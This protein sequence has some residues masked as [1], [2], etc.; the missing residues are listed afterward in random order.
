MS[1]HNHSHDISETSGIK[2]FFVVL[3]NVLITLSEFIGG[4][5]SGSLALLSDSIHN[6]SDV[7]AVALSYFAIKI[8]KKKKNIKKT[9]GYKRAQIIVAFINASVLLVISVFLIFEAYKKFTNPVKVN[10]M[11]MIYIAGIGLLANLFATLLL[12]KDSHKNLN[13]KSSYLHLLSDTIS[14]IGVVIGGIII[15][16]WAIYWVDPL[17]TVLIS[18]Y[19]I[20]QVWGIIKKS[21][22]IL[23]QSSA[24][25]DYEAIKQ[26]VESI[27][28]VINIHHVHTWL[29]DEKTIYFEAHVEVKD[30]KISDTTP[31]YKEISEIIKHKYGVSHITLQF[32]CGIC[33][34]K[35][36][37]NI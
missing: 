21:L 13:I 18:L 7:V 4:I 9:Y 5:I 36:L 20:K 10:S 34:N 8:S 15:K 27:E 17:V 3:L 37:F 23:M 19:I 2:I 32:E 33:D 25:L 30:M 11:L 22:N 16:I 1:D 6:L 26:D 14:S 12:L 35:N 24:D 31:I 29:A 28:S